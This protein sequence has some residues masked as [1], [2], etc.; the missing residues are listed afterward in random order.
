MRAKDLGEKALGRAEGKVERRRRKPEIDLIVPA[1]DEFPG[2]GDALSGN[3][4]QP[5]KVF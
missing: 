2:T 5:G 3:E 1:G 4:L